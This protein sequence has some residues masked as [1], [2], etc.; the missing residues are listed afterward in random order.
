MASAPSAKDM[1]GRRQ[2]IK[3]N[4]MDQS[5]W[6]YWPIWSIT[7][8]ICVSKSFFCPGSWLISATQA[9]Q[10]D[11]LFSH[12]LRLQQGPT[13]KRK[14]K[15]QEVHF[16]VHAQKVQTRFIKNVLARTIKGQEER[17]RRLLHILWMPNGKLA[18]WHS[19]S[20]L[21]REMRKGKD[22]KIN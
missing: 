8:S 14:K 1:Q 12:S 16:L 20:T 13:G 19:P 15:R 17:I 7:A 21:G 5:V 9:S 4:D 11:F 18:P 6:V 2:A 3:Q 10:M 22:A